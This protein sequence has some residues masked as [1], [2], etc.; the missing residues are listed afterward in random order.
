MGP[1]RLVLLNA[2]T[3]T[4]PRQTA[5]MDEKPSTENPVKK[6]FNKLDLS[7]LQGFSFGT[8]WA[9]EKAEP[10]GRADGREGSP[11]RSPE[12]RERDSH[13]ATPG[14]IGSRDRRNFRKPAGG[15]GSGGGAHEAA[16]D[17]TERGAGHGPRDEGRPRDSREF[18]GGSRRESGAPGGA[19]GE[20]RGGRIERGGE[21]GPRFGG[22]EGGHAGFRHEDR[23]PY[24]SPHFTVTFYP[25]DASFAAL[26]KTIRSSCRTFELFDIAK[27]VIG[28][29]ERFVVV[30]AR[31]SPDG[32][33][34]GALAP[35]APATGG[36]PAPIAISVPDGIPFENEESAIAHVLDKHL[37]AFF[38][39]A[40]V[41]VDPPKG[42][43][44]I[45]NRC[46]VTGE[47]LGPP[48]YHRYN[49]ILQQHFG[50]RIKGMSLEAFRT[51]VESVREPEVVNQWLEKMKKATRYSW[52]QT[53]AQPN[54]GQPPP[55]VAFDSYE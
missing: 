12:R 55:V 39:V 36:K 2:T 21:R 22:R 26:A 23:G 53:G 1:W 17:A 31:K 24:I 32:P 38:D 41:E 25:E 29:P 28:K 42:N 11:R 13:G 19:R 33:A 40:E 16:G 47:L 15:A 43:F 35:T 3:R 18:H 48:N 44:L 4:Y 50:S 10:H 5:V 8:Q 34:A 30:L 20:R 37:G 9:Q 46:G 45:V 49:Q 54:E 14:G 27:T 7:Q 52:K 6:D 51:R